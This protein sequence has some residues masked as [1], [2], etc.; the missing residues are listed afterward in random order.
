[1]KKWLCALLLVGGAL[2]KPD[3]YLIVPGRGFGAYGPSLTLAQMEKKMVP[4][5]YLEGESLGRPSA[6]IFAMDPFLRITMVV[7][8]RR[9]IRSM[10]VHGYM[11]KWHTAEGIRLGTSLARLEQINGRPFR[12]H[13]LSNRLES[14]RI[15]DWQGGNL[16]RRFAKVRLTF[17]SAM[18]SEGYSALTDQEKIRVEKAGL[19]LRSN[20][21]PTRKLNPIVETIELAF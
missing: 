3:P 10:F 16:A 8:H 17:A 1:M 5:D 18:H 13:A 11:G 19:I 12:F 2:A 9:Q 21:P 7:N 4:G 15:I 20:E 14:G 6:E